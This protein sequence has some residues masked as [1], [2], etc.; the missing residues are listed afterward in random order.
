MSKP[1]APVLSPALQESLIDSL[2]HTIADEI[3]AEKFDAT[4]RSFAELHD[5][6]DANVLGGQTLVHNWLNQDQS[7][8]II[9]T[10]Q[11]AIDRWLKLDDEG[12]E[13]AYMA[14]IRTALPHLESK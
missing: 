10:A 9:N 6:C 2:I 8:R 1:T 4:C 14:G 13:E 5:E 7:H 3:R 11:H 12:R